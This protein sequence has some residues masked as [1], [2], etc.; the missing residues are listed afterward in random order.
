MLYRYPACFY[1]EKEGGY[2]VIFPDLDHLAT[3]GDDPD[4]AMNM[5]AD[6]LAGY[7]CTAKQEGEMLPAPSDIKDIDVNSE[8]KGYKTAS[9]KMVSVDAEKYWK[10]HFQE[11][12]S[13]PKVNVRID[14]ELFDAAAAEGR[15]KSRSAAQQIDFWARVGRSALANPDLGAGDIADILEAKDLP[16][17]PF[18]PEGGK[19]KS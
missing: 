7:I 1:E 13:M 6:C 17:E 18:V 11:G 2:S 19:L 15:S 16:G 4:D 10:S 5:A 14:R 8:Y 9:V 12:M 3:Q